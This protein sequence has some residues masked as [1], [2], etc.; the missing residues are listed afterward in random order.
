[1]TPTLEFGYR[2]F[3]LYLLSLHAPHIFG[4]SDGFFTG[5]LNFIH[6]HDDIPFSGTDATFILASLDSTYSLVHSESFEF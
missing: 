5:N 4:E 1:M 6:A 3:V 2:N